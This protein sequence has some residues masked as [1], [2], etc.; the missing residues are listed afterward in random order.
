MNLKTYRQ[1]YFELNNL[2]GYNNFA[3]LFV[4]SVIFIDMFLKDT[5]DEIHV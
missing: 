3:N 5:L 2:Q 4:K 1:V